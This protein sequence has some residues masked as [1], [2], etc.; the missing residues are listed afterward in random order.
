VDEADP[1][2]CLAVPPGIFPRTETRVKLARD[3]AAR[4][5]PRLRA[6]EYPS[7]AKQRRHLPALKA[8]PPQHSWKL[9]VEAPYA[10]R[11][12]GMRGS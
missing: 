8:R 1:S 3:I 7:R 5:E 6:A 11:S 10:P 4:T 2:R 12:S 9:I